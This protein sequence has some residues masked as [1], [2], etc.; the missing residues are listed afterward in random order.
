[1]Y[2]WRSRTGTSS[3]APCPKAFASNFGRLG[4][5]SR[6]AY[7]AL[8]DG[9]SCWIYC[10]RGNPNERSCDQ[11]PFC[12]RFGS[13]ARP[14]KKRHPMPLFRVSG[15]QVQSVA[16][17]DFP[18]EKTLQ[19]II[20]KNLAAIFNCRFVATEFSTG[21]LH[22]GR[23]D[24]LA[25]S[26]DDNPVIIEY[27]RVVSS[28]LVNQSLFYLHWLNDHRGDFA[29]AVQRAL[30]PN[31]S[32]DWSAIRV[33]CIAPSYKKYDLHAVQVMGRNIE[34]WTYRRFINDTFYLEQT[35]QGDDLEASTNSRSK[36]PVMVTAGKKA[37]IT[38][39][40]STWTVDGRLE[41]KPES[42]RELFRTVQEYLLS[43]DSSIVEAPKKLYVAYRTTKNIVCVEVQK[44]KL[45]L[46]VK[47][48]PRK[49]LGP[50]GLARDVSKVGHFG[51]GDMEITL[52]SMADLELA[53][54]HL[55]K[56]YDAVGG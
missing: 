43:L 47:L 36:N 23:I 15:S 12:A 25:L 46:F 29:I 13:L 55:R 17:S 11:A 39:R 22:A 44:K 37:A 49:Y 5:Y 16:Q 50:K 8:A 45:L 21:A 26:E 31:V 19:G 51:T 38:R 18:A 3:G 9:Q 6:L 40:T 30:G 27:K 48:D 7:D 34:L 35:Q 10:S 33:I 53:K 41:G 1:M 2:S 54:P 52:R 20:E 32:I 4:E 42:I 28:E 24:T 56:A 14:P